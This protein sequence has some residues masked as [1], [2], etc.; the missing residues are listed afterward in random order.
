MEPLVFI[1]WIMGEKFSI[2]E[3]DSMLGFPRVRSNTDI[4]SSLI[5]KRSELTK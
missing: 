1:K 3:I 4:T 2:E 5:R